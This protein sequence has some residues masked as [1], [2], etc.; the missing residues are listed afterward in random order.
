MWSR[1]NLDYS[2]HH[3]AMEM[4]LLDDCTV[5]HIHM[6]CGL[7]GPNFVSPTLVLFPS[8]PRTSQYP[9]CNLWLRLWFSWMFV[10]H[11][12]AS[13]LLGQ[14]NKNTSIYTRKTVNRSHAVLTC[15]SCAVLIL[16]GLE[17]QKLPAFQELFTLWL[18]K[19][20]LSNSRPVWFG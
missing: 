7:E 4:W 12:R 11:Q 15:C 8:R 3:G 20:K 5:I 10:Q 2:E 17:D 19:S 13:E 16:Q 1:S 6:L 18:A 14:T 9:W